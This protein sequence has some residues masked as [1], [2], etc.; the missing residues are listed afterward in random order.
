MEPE[1]HRPII[2]CCV[3]QIDELFRDRRI[4][5]SKKIGDVR[6]CIDYRQL[7]EN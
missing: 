1:Y 4:E 3:L 2:L 7:N 5:P 6:M